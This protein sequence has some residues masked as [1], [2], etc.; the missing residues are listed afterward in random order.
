MT[1]SSNGSRSSAVPKIASPSEHIVRFYE[2]DAF[3]IDTVGAFLGAGLHAGE[4]CIVIATPSHRECLTQRLHADGHD[5]KAAHQQGIY[6]ALDAAETLEQFLMDEQPDAIRFAEVIGGIIQRAAAHG[7]PVR[8][9]GEMVAHLWK[10]GNTAATLRV[11]ALWNEIRPFLPPFS[12]CC[13]YAIQDFARVADSMPFV[14]I[15]QH[16]SQVVPDESFPALAG[17][18]ERLQAITFLQQKAQ[19]LETEIIERKAAEERLRQ[20]EH[21]TQEALSVLL[22]A[23]HIVAEPAAQADACTLLTQLAAMLYRLAGVD[24]AHALLVEDDPPSLMPIAIFGLSEQE[25]AAW[26]D[27]VMAFDPL[28]NPRASQMRAHLQ[29]GQVLVQ[30]FTTE[31]PLMAPFIVDRHQIREAISA[32]VLVDGR[33]V[34]LLTVAREQTAGSSGSQEFAPWDQELLLGVG[35]LAGKAIAQGHLMEQLTAARA[36]RLAAEMATRQRDLF[37][38]IASHE[39][40]TPLTIIK[41]NL[42]LATR[43]IAGSADMPDPALPL[44]RAQA[45]LQRSNRQ[46]ARLNRIIEDMLDMVRLQADTLQFQME[47]GDLTEIVRDAVAEQRLLW[48]ERPIQ[49]TLPEVAVMLAMDAGRISQVLENYLVNALKYSPP[50]APITVQM[51]LDAD[52]ARIAV[53]DQGPGLTPEEAQRVWE[54]FYRSPMVEVQSG[55]GVGLGLGLYLCKTVIERHGGQVGIESAPGQGATFWFTLPL[56]FL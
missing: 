27:T 17:Q 37:L 36:A 41:A 50:T 55:S 48:P 21:R 44:T 23:A 18:N 26:H 25:S 6:I 51:T 30:H 11:E 52:Q 14:E 15:C 16:H 10:Q 38:S 1:T 46:I 39:L 3:L 22:R 19:V 7:R 47:P 13:A 31:S 49:E 43:A 42:Q 56:L 9:F 29:A 34:G 53:T 32:P 45:L 20:S 2:T 5:L 12:L 28:S 4:A 33:L 40:R 54:R 24:T 8:V 35:R